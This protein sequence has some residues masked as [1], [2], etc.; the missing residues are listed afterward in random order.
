ME[1]TDEHIDR[2]IEWLN[3]NSVPNLYICDRCS[4][5]QGHQAVY[6][7][8]CSGKFRYVEFNTMADVIRYMGIKELSPAVGRFYYI[9]LF[10]SI[11]E[12]D[13]HIT[14]KEWEPIAEKIIQKLNENS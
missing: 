5:S 11:N 8:K 13:R 9:D 2:F 12:I 10:K 1:I 14:S 4:Y 3:S 6:C 7:P